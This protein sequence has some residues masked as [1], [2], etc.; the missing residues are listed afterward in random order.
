[1]GFANFGFSEILVVCLII[2]L[3]FG[4]KRIPEVAASFGKGIRE[5]KRGVHNIG[6]SI[7]QPVPPSGVRSAA[8]S[9]RD[10]ELDRDPRRLT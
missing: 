4:A 10:A 2:L 1:M 3:L 8:P 9:A 5:F 6:E 7:E